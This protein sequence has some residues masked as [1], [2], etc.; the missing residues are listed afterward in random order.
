[1][2]LLKWF[3]TADDLEKWHRVGRG[4][5]LRGRERSVVAATSD[6]GEISWQQVV[7]WAIGHAHTAM[8]VISTGAGKAA[9]PRPPLDNE[10]A[11]QTKTAEEVEPFLLPQNVTQLKSCSSQSRMAQIWRFSRANAVRCDATDESRP[12][13]DEL[14]KS[15]AATDCC[16]CCFQ[17]I[18]SQWAHSAATFPWQAN[19]TATPWSDLQLALERSRRGIPIRTRQTVGAGKVRHDIYDGLE[20]GNL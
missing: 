18:G 20:L 11:F 15:Y 12:L 16:C 5:K 3:G 10:A 7:I 4:T 14:S 6:S 17:R 19:P 13:L 2:D 9:R 8:L 1:M